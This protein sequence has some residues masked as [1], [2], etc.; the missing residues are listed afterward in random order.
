MTDFKY[1]FTILIDYFFVLWRDLV[2]IYYC[3]IFY[4]FLYGFTQTIVIQKIII[5][6]I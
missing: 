2:F 6:V 1:F 4:L 5:F 3:Y